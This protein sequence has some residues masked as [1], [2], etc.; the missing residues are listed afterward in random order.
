MYEMGENCRGCKNNGTVVCNRCDMYYDE[1]D[2]IDKPPI[3]NADRIRAMNDEKLADFIWGVETEGRAYGPRGR[4]AW[5][6]WLKQ[7]AT[8]E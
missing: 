5:I 8:H 4:K 7:E 6:D 1:F 2:P 3:T